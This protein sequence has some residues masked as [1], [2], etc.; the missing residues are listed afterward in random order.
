M[1]LAIDL[2]QD[3]FPMTVFWLSLSLINGSAEIVFSA[4]LLNCLVL[5]GFAFSLVVG[6]IPFQI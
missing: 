5:V 2:N 6:T 1:A 4:G 3:C